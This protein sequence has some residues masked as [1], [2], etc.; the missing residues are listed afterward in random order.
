M[1]TYA[2]P[3]GV[4][5]AATGWYDSDNSISVLQGPIHFNAHTSGNSRYV[6][7]KVVVE[8]D[9]AAWTHNKNDVW[10]A[11]PTAGFTN[12]TGFT[13][14]STLHIEYWIPMRHDNN[15]TWGGAY[16]DTNITFDNG[17]AWRSLGNPGYD[18]GVMTSPSDSIH[19][20]NLT[21]LVTQTPSTDYSVQ[22]RFMV[23]SYTDGSTL[24]I[25]QSHDINNSLSGFCPAGSDGV[26]NTRLSGESSQQG[27]GSYRI[28]EYIPIG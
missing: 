9:G 19:G 12:H 21:M 13:G 15:A 16:I 20:Q 27:F 28:Y 1:T 10:K 23:K 17:V 18:G 6:L 2:R 7:G 24:Q 11:W 26:A 4:D 8:S 3:S 25:N 5:S 14:G 22:L